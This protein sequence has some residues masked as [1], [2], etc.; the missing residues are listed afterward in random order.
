MPTWLNGMC[1][2]WGI[3]VVVFPGASDINSP[4]ARI[5]LPNDTTVPSKHNL[6]TDF[7][8]NELLMQYPARTWNVYVSVVEWVDPI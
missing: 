5:V 7:G 1:Y 8:N 4:L 3:V 6:N 2:G